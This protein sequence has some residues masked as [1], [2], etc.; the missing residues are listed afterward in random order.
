M[1]RAIL[2]LI[3]ALSLSGIAQALDQ[4]PQPHN[5]IIITVQPGDTLWEIAGRYMEDGQNIQEAMYII[6]QTNPGKI[7]GG[8]VISGEKLI[9]PVPMSMEAK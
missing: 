7:P 8:M 6:R 9:I 3:I 2:A 1:K 5:T 4:A